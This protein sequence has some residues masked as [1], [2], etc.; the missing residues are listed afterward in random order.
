MIAGLLVL[1]TCQ[2]LGTVVADVLGL[3]VPGRSSA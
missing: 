1:L 2:L 3:P